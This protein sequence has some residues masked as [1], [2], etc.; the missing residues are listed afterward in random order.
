MDILFPDAHVLCFVPHT[1]LWDTERI[2]LLLIDYIGF[3]YNAQDISGPSLQLLQGGVAVAGIKALCYPYTHC[4]C[5]G[6]DFCPPS[7]PFSVDSTNPETTYS[8]HRTS[9]SA[10]FGALSVRSFLVLIYCRLG[11]DETCLVS[12]LD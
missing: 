4:C 7:P 6:L 11:N 9:H 12:L 8:Y 2:M 5:L 1:S 10:C 3:G